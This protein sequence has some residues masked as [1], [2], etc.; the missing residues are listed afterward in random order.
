MRVVGAA[1]GGAV[2][3]VPGAALGYYLGD[4]STPN[5]DI[6]DPT[7]ETGEGGVFAQ[8]ESIDYEE[9]ARLQLDAANRIAEANLERFPQISQT[10]LDVS[11][12]ASDALQA[13]NNDQYRS[14]LNA[15][16]PRYRQ[17]AIQTQKAAIN[18]RSE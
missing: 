10:A 18:S 15:I 16:D 11:Q 5:I 17:Y 1:M 7:S 12:T 2:F 8:M 3:G 9:M 4:M 6:P 13:W 14:T